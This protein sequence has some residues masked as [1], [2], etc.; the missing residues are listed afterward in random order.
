MALHGEKKIFKSPEK[1]SQEKVVCHFINKYCKKQ[2][3]MFVERI[4]RHQ[5]THEEK[6]LK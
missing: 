5:E 1:T 2:C 4:S 3:V 6:K